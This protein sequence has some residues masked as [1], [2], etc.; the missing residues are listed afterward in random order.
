MSGRHT[1]DFDFNVLK[2]DRAQAHYLGGTTKLNKTPFQEYLEKE[3]EKVTHTNQDVIRKQEQ[4][5]LQDRL[6]HKQ[7]MCELPEEELNEL[8]KKEPSK[9]EPFIRG[10][11]FEKKDKKRR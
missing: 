7:T 10:I 4:Q 8:I 2:G 5:L 3:T 1:K 6:N 11:G 9:T